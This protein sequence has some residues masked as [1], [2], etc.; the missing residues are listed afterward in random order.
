M[1]APMVIEPEGFALMVSAPGRSAQPATARDATTRRNKENFMGECLPDFGGDGKG[2][3]APAVPETQQDERQPQ[4][5]DKKPKV[6]FSNSAS[7]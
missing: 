5:G 3:S 4:A 6:D 1:V 2:L 7:H